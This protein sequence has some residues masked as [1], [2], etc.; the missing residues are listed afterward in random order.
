[1][2][3]EPRNPAWPGW[4]RLRVMGRSANRAAFCDDRH[5]NSLLT[6][7]GGFEICARC[8]GVRSAICFGAAIGAGAIKQNC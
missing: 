4:F 7:N 3:G 6:G 1:V 8:C 2:I 5:R